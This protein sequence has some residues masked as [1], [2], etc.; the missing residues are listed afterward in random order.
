MALH[1]GYCQ[2]RYKSK[3]KTAVRIVASS[4]VPVKT[5]FC[6]H[7]CSN[8]ANGQFM[9]KL[10]LAEKVNAKA[11]IQIVDVSGKIVNALQGMVIDGLMQKTITTSP[12]QAKGLYMIRVFVNNNT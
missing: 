7:L 4:Q 1:Q 12:L 2:Q 8:P 6:R 9:L 11:L 3:I 10:N 5:L